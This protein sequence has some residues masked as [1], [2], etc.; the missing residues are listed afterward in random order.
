MTG[1]PAQQI[2]AHDMPIKAVKFFEAPNSNAPMV[3]T[4]SWD[5]S[6]KYWDLRTDSA[7]VTVNCDER[8]Y[9]LDVAKDLLAFS[10][11]FPKRFSIIDLKNPGTILE[12][13]DIDL[14]GQMRVVACSSDAKT[15]A[16]GFSGGRAGHYFVNPLEK[17]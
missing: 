17:A 3:V 16:V 4:G 7:V 12:T 10:T 5:K 15:M 6:I 1:A 9:S 13:R 14:N 2:A 11:T 8:G